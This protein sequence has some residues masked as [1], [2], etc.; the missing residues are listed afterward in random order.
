MGLRFGSW[1]FVQFAKSHCFTH[2]R[3]SPLHPQGNGESERTVKTINMLLNKADDKYIV[4]LNYRSTP[5]QHGSNP[6]ELLMGRKL[7]K[8]Q[9]TLKKKIIKKPRRNCSTGSRT[10]T[11]Q[12]QG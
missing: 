12:G 2:L 3:S 9:N 7:I 1:N 10:K 5:L 4:L 6:K 11:K 8:N